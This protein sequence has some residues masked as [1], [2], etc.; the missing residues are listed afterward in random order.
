MYFYASMRHDHRNKDEMHLIR[1]KYPE[2][3]PITVGFRRIDAPVEA[4]LDM[5]Y[6]LEMGVVVSGE[7]VR[8]FE[9]F[10]QVMGPG[11]V[12][13]SGIWEPHGFA[14]PHPPAEI[15]VLVVN[16]DLLFSTESN[17]RWLSPFLTSASQRS[18]IAPGHRA[19]V[20]D[21]AERFRQC[22]ELP[23][24]LRSDWKWVLL[25]EILLLLREDQ[26][27]PTSRR[28][29]PGY[30]S[31]LP[32]LRATFENTKRLSIGEAAQACGMSRDT[33][34]KRFRKATGISFAKF[35]L[36]RRLQSVAAQLLHTDA[37]I[38]NIAHEWGFVDV[39]HL[40]KCFK[41]VYGCS[42]AEYRKRN[43]L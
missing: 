20:L 35:A 38:K 22:R 2:R 40:H 28:A 1:I 3:D 16:P 30:Q 15:M 43:V 27:R 17:A 19:R 6:G 10:R 32:G 13:V 11:G 21:I 29:N 41:E 23:E 14:V 4:R 42:A 7:V 31:I 12:W 25:M 36:R 5:H 24:D 18:G 34:E 33:F 39:S 37:A 9:D 26:A 8:L